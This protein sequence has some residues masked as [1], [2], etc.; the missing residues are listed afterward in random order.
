MKKVDWKA[1]YRSASNDRDLWMVSNEAFGLLLLENSW[2]RWMDIFTQSKGHV[3]IKRGA[4]KAA[5]ESQVPPKYTWGGVVYSDKSKKLTVDTGC[6]KGWSREGII[7]F[8]ELF[9]QVSKDRLAHLQT[10]FRHIRFSSSPD[11]NIFSTNH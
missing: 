11:L 7:R 5:N 9:D 4:K 2:D 3:V 6:G 1:R 8:N 10:L